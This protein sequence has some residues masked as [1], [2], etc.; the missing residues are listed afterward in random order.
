MRVSDSMKVA[1]IIRDAGGEI[2]GRTRLQ[3]TA[4]LLSVA[5]FE[6]GFSFVYKHYGPF[7]ES[8]A[9]AA[10]D[11]HLLG[12]LKETIQPTHWGGTYSVYHVEAHAS[13]ENASDPQAVARRALAKAAAA[14]SAVEL[15]LAAT[16][17]F[18]HIEGASDPWAETARRKPEKALGGR[19][20]RAKTLLDELRRIETPARL[21]Q[22]H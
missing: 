6:D 16:A 7:S 14:A 3:K 11:G 10:R 20:E 12:R 1:A 8:V 22:L 9:T 4:Y 2:V 21:P 13:D 15:E 17:V 18:L 5:G 19:I